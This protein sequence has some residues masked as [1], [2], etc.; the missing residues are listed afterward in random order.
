MRWPSRRVPR[1][2]SSS[3]SPCARI[4]SVYT[5]PAVE[6][7]HRPGPGQL[8]G[9]A[10]RDVIGDLA[11]QSDRIDLTAIGA[12]ATLPGNQAFRFV[13]TAPL[14]GAGQL[15]FPCPP[16]TRSSAAAPTGTPRPSSRFSSPP[17]P[18]S[19]ATRSTYDGAGHWPAV[20]LL[21]RP[22]RERVWRRDPAAGTTM[23][24]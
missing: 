12:D 20:S 21:P 22:H 4:I 24:M 18:A 3:S 7:F 8:P 17:S 16:A 1:V 19:A 9:S 13:D 15:G 2:A 6:A 5:F 14:D 23:R 11:P 10:N